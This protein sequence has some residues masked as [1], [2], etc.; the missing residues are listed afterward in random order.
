MV[1]QAHHERNQYI[2]VRPEPVE[3]LNQRFLKLCQ[4]I[5]AFPHANQLFLAMPVFLIESTQARN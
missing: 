1:R 3:G 5:V 4:S 2:T